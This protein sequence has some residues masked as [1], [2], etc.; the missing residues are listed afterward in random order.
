MTPTPIATLSVTKADG[1]TLKAAVGKN[2][3]TMS[4]APDP[5][6]DG[7]FDVTVVGHEYG[8]F[9][10]H[11]LQQCDT[12]I[13]RGMSE[14][15]ADFSALLVSS[16]KGDDFGAQFPLAIFSTRGISPESQYYGIRRAPYTTNHAINAL[17]FRHMAVGEALPPAPFNGGDPANNNEVHNVGEV[18]ASMLWEGYAALQTQ[19]GADFDATRLKMRQ[20]EVAGLMMAPAEG[21]PTETRDAILM[22]ARAK[23]ADDY[24]VLA[25]AYAKRGFGSCAESPDRNSVDLNPIVES[26]ELKGRTDPGELAATGSQSCDNDDVLDP[27]EQFQL[28][29]PIVNGGAA[30]LTGVTATLNSKLVTFD[31][32]TKATVTLGDLDIGASASATFNIKLADTVTA[33]TE[34]DVTISIASADGCKTVTVPYIAR[35]NAD[36]EPNASTVET[37]DAGGLAWTASHVAIAG[38]PAFTDELWTHQRIDGLNG[39]VIGEA[40]DAP[41][42][43]SLTSPDLVAGSQ[44]VSF[45]FDAAWQFETSTQ[46]P[47]DGGVIEYSTDKG[48]TWTDIMQLDPTVAYNATLRV[49][50]DNVLRG[51]KAFGDINP[52][53]VNGL[54]NSIAVNF[55][56]LLANQTF[57]IRFR[58]GTD[59]GTGGPGWLIDNVAFTGLTNKPFPILVADGNHCAP[60]GATNNH[61]DGG[62]CQAGGMTTGNLAAALGVLGLVLRRRRRAVR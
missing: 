25:Q 4:R 11:R 13:C 29:I 30:K 45:T 35:F 44:P 54:T 22:A 46:G 8:H 41:S 7:T 17:S 61:D 53:L 12:Q 5:D 18:W 50:S 16:R 55:G 28:V 19:P 21:T 48:A 23:S 6:L 57:R 40:S 14:G 49:D 15:W 39:L 38:V 58:I 10:H 31:D 56:T 60:T 3:V 34:S 36:D 24:S 52:G 27:G 33:P 59:S 37:F 9:V 20:Y 47:V 43:T 51:R 1:A 26:A 42:D 62:C 2:T 32:P